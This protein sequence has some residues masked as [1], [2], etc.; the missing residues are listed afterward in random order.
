MEETGVCILQ[1]SV[2]SR[3][4][5]AV[6]C[7]F[8]RESAAAN[9]LGQGKKIGKKGSENFVC[10]GRNDTDQ[11]HP[12]CALKP[13]EGPTVQ[14]QTHPNLN[15]YPLELLKPGCAKKN[16][17]NPL[18]ENRRQSRIPRTCFSATKTGTRA[19]HSSARTVPKFRDRKP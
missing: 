14:E 4:K 19:A 9:I 12:I 2:G 5:P 6:C 3:R 10:I 15:L 8:L 1:E 16:C 13:G 18:P 11:I 7:G 17:Q